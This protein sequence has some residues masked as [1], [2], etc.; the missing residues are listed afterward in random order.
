MDKHRAHFPI[1][2]VGVLLALR[3]A[4]LFAAD[5]DAVLASARAAAGVGDESYTGLIIESG[6]ERES[7]LNGRWRKTVDLGTGKIRVVADFGV[8]STGVVWDGRRYW[9]QDSSGGV[10]P[11][12]SDFMHAVHVT[13]AGVVQLA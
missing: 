10:H 5:P 11:I 1:T 6:S 3:V 12:D 8:F 7:G 2:A 13:D 9:R 4:T